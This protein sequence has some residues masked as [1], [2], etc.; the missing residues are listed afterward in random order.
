MTKI[1]WILYRGET[2]QFHTC[3]QELLAPIRDDI[4]SFK[5]F[6]SDLNYMAD[7]ADI[8]INL[9]NDY[10]MLSNDEFDSLLAHH[11]QFIWGTILGFPQESDISFDADALPYVEGND[12]IWVPGNMQIPGAVIEINCFDSS[13]TIVKFSDENLSKKF[14]GFYPEFE[15]L[16]SFKG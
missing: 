11:I 4:R 12:L 9:D 7:S 10:F 14:H 2:F 6:L 3:L 16:D 5:W 1:D 15:P 13:A 8:P